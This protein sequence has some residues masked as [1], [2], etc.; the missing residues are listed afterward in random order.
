MLEAITL[1]QL[2]TFLAVTDEGSFS[3]A[4]RKLGRV[5]SAVSHAMVNLEA[6]L[7]VRLWD[8]S[9]KRP[10]LTAEGAALVAA[11]RRVMTDV[12]ALG[13]IAEGMV[14]GL[15]P[16]LALAVDALVPIR[17]L[18]D[19]CREFALRFPTVQL[20]IHTEILSAV[21]SLVADGTC[22]MGVVGPAAHGPGLEREHLAVVRMIP[23]VGKTHPLARRRGSIPTAQLGEHIHIVLSER[24]GGRPTPDQG[25]LSAHTWRVGDLGTKHALLVAGLGWGN[26][27]EHVAAEDLARGR[28]VEIRPAAW[29][30]DEWRLSLSLAH[31]PELVKGPATRWVMAR[32][33]ELCLRDLGG[34]RKRVP[35]RRSR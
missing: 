19:L 3:A 2:R 21:S 18:V 29:G 31:R 5:Q 30:P 26:L 6:Q 17:A 32:L 25:V 23:V 35:P 34:V 24:A 11:A 33:K 16:V 28:L 7:G 8:R 27:P 9:T 15:E 4:G 22:Q 14:G 10:T 13:R 20:R 12:D 1:D